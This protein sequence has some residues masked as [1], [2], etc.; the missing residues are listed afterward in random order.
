[1]KPGFPGQE[2]IREFF[3]RLADDWDQ[4]QV[5]GEDR[6]RAIVDLACLCPGDRVLDVGTG[7]GVLLALLADRVRPHG[8]V[9][10]V[11]LSPQ[12]LAL[13][14]RKG[15][16]WGLGDELELLQADVHALPFPEGHFAAVLCYSAFPHF[17]RQAAAV[18]EMARV[19]CPGGR[20]V[21][22]HNESREAVNRRHREIGGAIG[23]HELPPAGE[24]RRLLA[25]Q[26]LGPVLLKDEADSYLAVAVRSC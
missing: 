24:M 23:G 6:L 14:R 26:R 4:D 20:L 3:D 18:G 11:D 1:M 21:I 16:T 12:M 9:V 22:A 8:R 2:A 7:T 13:A 10:G 15:V 17:Q 19:L 25:S 5:V